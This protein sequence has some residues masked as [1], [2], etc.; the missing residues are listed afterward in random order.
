MKMGWLDTRIEKQ[1]RQQHV[2]HETNR[3]RS[4]GQ[5]YVITDTGIE[6]KKEGVRNQYSE[7]GF[8]RTSFGRCWLLREKSRDYIRTR[9]ALILQEIDKKDSLN[10]N[11]A[12]NVSQ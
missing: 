4:I 3:M 1:S 6:G 10:T 12:A 11:I 8:Q 2:G 9:R 5:A 7:S